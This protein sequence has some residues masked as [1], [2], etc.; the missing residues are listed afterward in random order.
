MAIEINVL[1]GDAI[2]RHDNCPFK[3]F[4]EACVRDPQFRFGTT[5]E[6]ATERQIRARLEGYDLRRRTV[7]QIEHATFIRMVVLECAR[8]GK[9]R[10]IHE[11]V[12]A[13]HPKG[14]ILCENRIS[15]RNGRL[16]S[17]DRRSLERL[18]IVE[19][20][21]QDFDSGCDDQA[22]PR[23]RAVLPKSAVVHGQRRRLRNRENCKRKRFWARKAFIT[24]ECTGAE[25]PRRSL[26][27]R[28]SD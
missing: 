18:V 12:D 3:R 27:K 25:R 21:I 2:S 28:A 7:D 26:K 13:P 15:D 8:I 1:S 20:G 16:G 17:E 23:G 9:E 14:K 5:G 10:S 22:G 4:L 19:D 24:H 6:S 11:I